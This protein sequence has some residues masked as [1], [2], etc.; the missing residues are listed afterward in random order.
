MYWYITT[1]VDLQ[2]PGRIDNIGPYNASGLNSSSSVSCNDSAATSA[3][4]VM[5]TSAS[6]G[7]VLIEPY[8]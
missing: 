5:K 7:N 1:G 3:T 4:R 2:R 8:L 6:E